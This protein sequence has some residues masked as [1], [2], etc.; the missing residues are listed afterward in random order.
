MSMLPLISAVYLLPT[1]SLSN[2]ETTKFWSIC[3]V[4]K[5]QLQ[6]ANYVPYSAVNAVFIVLLIQ[7]QKN[8]C[9]STHFNN[10]LNFISC[11][12]NFTQTSSIFLK[13]KN[14][15]DRNFTIPNAKDPMK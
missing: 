5:A 1:K 4:E 10:L 14:N 11:I 6:M 12:V 7:Y 8:D 3:R 13:S 15:S 9:R 2:I